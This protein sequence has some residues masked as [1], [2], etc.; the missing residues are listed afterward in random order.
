M[1]QRVDPVPDTTGQIGALRKVA[2]RTGEAQVVG[3]IGAV[4]LLRHDVLDMERQE[5]GV[6]LV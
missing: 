4:V 3:V 2:L 1:E 5:V 6:V